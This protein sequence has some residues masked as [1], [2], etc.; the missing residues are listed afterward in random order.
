MLTTVLAELTLDNPNTVLWLG[1]P[2]VL[3]LGVLIAGLLVR[4]HSRQ[5]GAA[6]LVLGIGGLVLSAG[7]I[8]FAFYVDAAL[9]DT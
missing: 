4:R 2:V 8:A 6:L 5:A 7:W 3:S 9:G 1:G